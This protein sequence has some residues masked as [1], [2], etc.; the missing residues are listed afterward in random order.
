VVEIKQDEMGEKCNTHV[1]IRNVYT[2]LIGKPEGMR[3]LGRPRHIWEDN[4]KMNI[5][6]W[7]VRLWT[8]FVWLRIGTSDDIL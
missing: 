8:G 2:V 6:K 3:P 1:K 7:G 5:K 4:I